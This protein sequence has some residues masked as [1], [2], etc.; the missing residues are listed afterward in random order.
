MTA[1]NTPA[2]PPAAAKAPKPAP[3]HFPVKYVGRH[4][5]MTDQLYRTGA[6][7]PGTVKMVPAG[8]AMNMFKHIDAFSLATPEEAKG[9]ETADPTKRSTAEE[10]KRMDEAAMLDAIDEVRGMT[11]ERAIEYARI[12]YGQKVDGRL[13]EEN[14]RKEVTSLIERFGAM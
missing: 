9:A 4:A 7:E 8:I 12:Y 2:K 6:Y 11:K 5:R 3:T 1:T 10:A 13:S 14:A